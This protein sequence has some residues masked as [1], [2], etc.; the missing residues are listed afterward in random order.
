MRTENC[1]RKGRLSPCD[2]KQERLLYLMSQGLGNDKSLFPRRNSFPQK[3]FA[4]ILKFS[5]NIDRTVGSLVGKNY[6]SVF[7]GLM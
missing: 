6:W 4:S 7:L 5:S 1:R 3:F 2:K